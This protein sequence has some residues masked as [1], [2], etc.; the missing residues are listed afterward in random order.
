M[1]IMG[2]AVPSLALGAN[3]RLD[4]GSHKGSGRARLAPVDNLVIGP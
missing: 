4:L 3:I 2:N 1:R